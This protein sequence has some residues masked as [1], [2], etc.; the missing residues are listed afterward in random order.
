MYSTQLGIQSPPPPT[1]RQKLIPVWR[2]S[3]RP[4]DV[5]FSRYA[6]SIAGKYFRVIFQ[7]DPPVVQEPATN[8]LGTSGTH[9]PGIRF[10]RFTNTLSPPSVVMPS[11]ACPLSPKDAAYSSQIFAISTSFS[12][13]PPVSCVV[14]RMKTL[15]Y[16]WGTLPVSARNLGWSEGWG[17]IRGMNMHLPIPDDAGVQPHW[18]QPG[19]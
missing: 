17:G 13:I 19:S 14:H 15:L 5:L 12:E 7:G 3:D 18:W 10:T 4:Y 8:Q 1:P 9:H 11:A 6:Y 16:V 2:Y